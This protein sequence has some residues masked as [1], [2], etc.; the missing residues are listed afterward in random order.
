MPH[1]RHVMDK[2]ELD[3]ITKLH[4]E[5]MEAIN[6]TDGKMIPGDDGSTVT[7]STGQP[8]RSAFKQALLSKRLQGVAPKGKSPQM[9]EITEEDELVEMV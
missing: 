6:G 9:Q 4:D 5:F 2:A 7:Y 8:M 1:A 3:M